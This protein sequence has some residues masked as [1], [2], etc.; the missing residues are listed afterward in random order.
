MA[1]FKLAEDE[2]TPIVR[3]LVWD[4]GA[5]FENGPGVTED[6]DAIVHAFE[7]RMPDVELLRD[8]ID[9]RETSRLDQLHK[10]AMAAKD[11]LAETIGEETISLHRLESGQG[12]YEGYSEEEIQDV[13]EAYR[14]SI[15]EDTAQ[16]AAVQSLIY[17]VAESKREEAKGS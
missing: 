6:P 3:K 17:R 5:E 15:A 1:A 16:G 8:L 4:I 12:E 2:I 10:A 7:K 9:R 14:R 13:A 11:V